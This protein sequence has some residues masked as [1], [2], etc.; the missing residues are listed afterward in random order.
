MGLAS[1]F[2]SVCE[3]LAFAILAVT[4]KRVQRSKTTHTDP[5]AAAAYSMICSA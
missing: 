1:G 5:A 2:S 4:G 3:A